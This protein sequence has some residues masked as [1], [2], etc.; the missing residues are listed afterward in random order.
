V[1]VMVVAVMFVMAVVM[2]FVAMMRHG[3][4]PYM[5]RPSGVSFS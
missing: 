3:A 5:Y 2:M 4:P 1:V